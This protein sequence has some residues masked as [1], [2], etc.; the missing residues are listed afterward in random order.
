[1]SPRGTLLR[2]PAPVGAELAQSG[3]ALQLIG[4]DELDQTPHGAVVAQVADPPEVASR[5]LPRQQVAEVVVLGGDADA[6]VL[7]E[8]AAH[9]RR[10]AAADAHDEDGLRLAF[11]PGRSFHWLPSLAVAGADGLPRRALLRQPGLHAGAQ[12]TPRGDRPSYRWL[13]PTLSLAGAGG[14]GLDHRHQPA[15][16]HQPVPAE[17]PARRGHPGARTSSCSTWPSSP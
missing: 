3:A 15:G 13:L 10:A 16:R 9:Q 5:A 4:V 8:D 1:M 17:V 7:V 6:T 11:E 14:H 2:E 12:G